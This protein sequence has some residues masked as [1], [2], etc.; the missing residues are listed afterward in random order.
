MPSHWRYC[1]RIGTIDF[2]D[3][4]DVVHYQSRAQ[5]VTQATGIDRRRVTLQIVVSHT[6]ILRC[7]ATTIDLVAALTNNLCIYTSTAEIAGGHGVDHV[8]P[9][10]HISHRMLGS[11][12]VCSWPPGVGVDAP[13]SI[14][15]SR[16]WSDC[17][18][19]HTAHARRSGIHTR[20]SRR[21]ACGRS[22]RRTPCHRPRWP[23]S[24]GPT[25]PS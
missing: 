7:C 17:V 9:L 22:T 23:A 12:P 5:A 21:T 6:G 16:S 4:Y 19:R 20:A 8:A 3:E 11:R 24:C 2:G 13:R 25:R 18:Q 10:L 15:S 14:L 1:D